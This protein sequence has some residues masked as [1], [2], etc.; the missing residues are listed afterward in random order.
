M[1][2][3]QFAGG[4]NNGIPKNDEANR[5]K[6]LKD[7]PMLYPD[8]GVMDPGYYGYGVMQKEKPAFW[9]GK[10]LNLPPVFGW[11]SAIGAAPANIQYPGWLNINRT[12]DFATSVTKIAGR[13]TLK[14]GGYLNHSYKAQNV[15]AG[16]IANLSFQGY[17]NFGNDTTNA[18]DSG[19]GYAN[20]SL[21][22]F[23]QYLQ[24]SKFIEGNMLYNQLEFFVQDNW[25]VTNR[26]TLDYGMRF[27]HQQPQYDSFN[28]MSN[29]FPEKWKASDAPVFYVA[30]CSNGAAVCSGNT[31]NAMDPRTGQILVAAGAANSQAA[32][33][34]PI[35]G[36]GNPLNGIIQAGNGIAKTNYEWP[37][38]V[39]GPRFG[40]AYDVN[41]KS[42]W[43]IRGGFGLFYD[44]PD[45]NTVFSTPGNPPIATAT[46]LRNGQLSTLGKGLAPQ[47]VPALVTF[48]YHAQVPSSW[49]WQAGFQKSLP[50]AMV[51]DVMYVGNHG[52]NRLGS[53]QGGTQQPINIGRLR[54][55]VSGEE[56][57]PDAGRGYLSRPDRL[58]HQSAPPLPGFQHDRTEYDG[59]L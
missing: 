21:G 8:A 5:L 40:F 26:L 1:I 50:F 37:A 57:G 52:Y 53:L 6:S 42:D 22:I 55:G 29:F 15:G 24:A 45:G 58:P 47:P 20:A 11:G 33:G 23:T 9:D 25:K 14:A 48:Q 59:F 10:S 28:H 31:R 49:Q 27:V 13:H 54:R 4:N 3:N 17:V 34:T 7:F 46:D 38:V 32:I 36:T 51:G 41:G 19:F 43:V 16:G 35:P 39:V 56:P 2:Q 18:L 30:G 12:R 44:R